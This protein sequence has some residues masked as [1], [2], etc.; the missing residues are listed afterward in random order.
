MKLALLSLG[1]L[2]AI[3]LS[4]SAAALA[5]ERTPEG[6]ATPVN[7]EL[8]D[9]ALKLTQ[10]EA[11]KYELTLADEGKSVARLQK[12]PVL[13][14]SNPSVGE[15]HG[16]VF[17]W[18]VESRPVAVGSLFKWFTPHTHMSHEFHSLTE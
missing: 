16:N 9:A 5:Q 7:K 3:A 12:D 2:A 8:I 10:S 15:I 11:A 17:L 13:K 18:T 4:A 14:W 6:D 1:V